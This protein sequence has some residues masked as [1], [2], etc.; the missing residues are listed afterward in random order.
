MS[1]AHPASALPKSHYIYGL[2]TYI[3]KKVIYIY[4]Y[5]LW[6]RVLR[7]HDLENVDAYWVDG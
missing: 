2:T 3:V 4:T 5:I 6:R 1:C 7:L